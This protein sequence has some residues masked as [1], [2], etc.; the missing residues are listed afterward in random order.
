MSKSEICLWLIGIL[1]CY[2]AIAAWVNWRWVKDDRLQCDL[3]VEE[4]EGVEGN[5]LQRS[6][7]W[8]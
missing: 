5:P 2:A 3:D 7:P 4:D 6:R 1:C 8:K